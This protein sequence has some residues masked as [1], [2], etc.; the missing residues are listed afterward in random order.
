ME[1]ILD[2]TNTADATKNSDVVVFGNP[3][4][5]QL[6]CKASSKEQGW[7]KSVMGIEVEGLGVVVR[8]QV[9][10]RNADGSYS[11]SESMCF[12]PG[13]TIVVSSGD[14]GVT[15]GRRLKKQ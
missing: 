15:T 7:M 11:L 14:G 12:V 9:Q 1:K 6:L 2:N 5:L 8:S 13:A 10:Q 4:M 3:D